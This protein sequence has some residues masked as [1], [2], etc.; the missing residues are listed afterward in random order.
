[1]K[2]LKEPKDLNKLNF[3]DI[4]FLKNISLDEAK[5]AVAN[6]LYTEKHLWAT[7]EKGVYINLSKRMI[8][9][10]KKTDLIDKDKVEVKIK[11]CSHLEGRNL[12][13]YTIESYNK[14]VDLTR[15]RKY[16][17][18]IV[19]SNSISFT[20]K[21]DV[22]N[23]ILNRNQLL[24]LQKKWVLKNTYMTNRWSKKTIDFIKNNS[25]VAGYLS[26]F[27]DFDSQFKKQ[28]EKLNNN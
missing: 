11:S 17:E 6:F 7:D 12:I 21:H 25:W 9:K 18:N 16:S 22:L 1:M 3:N 24:L 19:F 26:D 27:F 10:L 2:K 20:G 4:S 23:D 13:D 14:G 8:P 28:L 15:L 5:W